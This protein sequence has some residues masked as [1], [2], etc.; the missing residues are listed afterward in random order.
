MTK[1]IRPILEKSKVE[2]LLS[3]PPSQYTTTLLREWLAN[4]QSGEAPM[5]PEAIVDIPAEFLITPPS[6]NV[7][8]GNW[9]IRFSKDWGKVRS[10]TVGRIIFNNLVFANSKELRSVT[11][12]YDVVLNSGKISDIQQHVLDMYL[13]KR[14]SYEDIT[15]FIDRCQWLG[16]GSTAFICP[17]LTI[18]TI[19]APEKTRKLKET[20]LNSE[21]GVKIR[22]GDLVE[23]SRAEKELLDLA[24]SELEN[25]D[26]GLD[27]FTSGA[28]GSMGN[29]YKNIAIMRGA[30]RKSDDP[31]TISVSTASLEEG[32]PLE[33]MPIYADLL[34]QASFGRAMLTATGGYFVKQLNAAF[35]SLQLNPDPESDCKSTIYRRT[36]IDN[37]REYAFRFFNA[38]GNKLTEILPDE[39]DSYRGKIV[40]MRSPLYCGDKNGI[41]SR[42][43][44]TLHHRM[45]I[46]SIGLITGRIGS[47]ILNSALKAF[48]D[49][50]LKLVRIDLAK[51]TREIPIET[52]QE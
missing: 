15:Y 25:V 24:K 18:N 52:R 46:T 8:T 30:I 2:I 32:I 14:I 36:L 22:E 5:P 16:Y 12:Y 48:H 7:E 37:P 43:A 40:D 49:T 45:G 51:Y 26:P 3:T 44:G 33:E 11:P 21:R 9:D 10:T 17:S 42:C 35:Q 29:N 19:R 1:L 6:K 50:T 4:K 23:L 13:M 31:S 38:G 34:V 27:I 41:C 47:T 39:I 20:I 28:R